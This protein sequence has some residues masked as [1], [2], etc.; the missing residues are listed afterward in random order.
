MP[1]IEIIRLLDQL[2]DAGQRIEAVRHF[3]SAQQLLALA[4]FYNWD[5][6]LSVPRAIADH[7][8]CDLGLALRL[9]ELAEGTVYLSEPDRDWKYQQDWAEFCRELSQRILAGH[10]PSVMIPF[11]TGITAV[12][13]LKLKRQGIPEIFYTPLNP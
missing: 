1:S 12:Q 5:D 7:P 10:Y 2:E 11:A 13:C 3:S 8:A 4:Q 6:G 9:F